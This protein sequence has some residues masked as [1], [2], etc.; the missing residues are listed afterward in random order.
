MW[1]CLLLAL[2]FYIFTL[3]PSSFIRYF[4]FHSSVQRSTVIY[5]VFFSLS[6]PI[7]VMLHS[8]SLALCVLLICMIKKNDVLM[9]NTTFSFRLVLE[10]LCRFQNGQ[11][12]KS[13]LIHRRIPNLC[14]SQPLKSI[15]LSCSYLS[16]QMGLN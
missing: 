4:C 15:S 6:P 12:H 9:L 16:F 8:T 3:F 10:K 11:Q 1:Y 14:T 13:S 7:G 2:L 5:W